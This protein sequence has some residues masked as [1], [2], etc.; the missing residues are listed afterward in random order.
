MLVTLSE[1]AKPKEF[2]VQAGVT[3]YV[4]KADPPTPEEIAKYKQLFP[5]AEVQ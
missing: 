5:H 3:V 4:G 1:Q 2:E